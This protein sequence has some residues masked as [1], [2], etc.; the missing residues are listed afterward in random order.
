[1]ER[2]FTSKVVTKKTAVAVRPHKKR[3][4]RAALQTP[5]PKAFVAALIAVLDSDDPSN[6]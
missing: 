6:E 4:V 2:H 3:D 1:M 5:L